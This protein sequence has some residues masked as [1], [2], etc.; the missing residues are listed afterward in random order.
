MSR[1]KG[2]P[3][4]GGR[5]PGSPNKFT[6]E[7]RTAFAIAFEGVGGVKKLIEWAKDHQSEFY[8]IYARLIPHEVYAKVN[9]TDQPHAV[10][11]VNSWLE[12]TFA[13][14]VAR[15]AEGSRTH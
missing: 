12:E 7:A 14:E 11:A 9:V 8:R 4:T 15:D 10:Q 6:V 13:D 2:S 5:R 1:V 3:K